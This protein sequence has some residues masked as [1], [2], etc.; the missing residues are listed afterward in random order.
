MQRPCSICTKRALNCAFSSPTSNFIV[1]YQHRLISSALGAY[2]PTSELSYA[3][4]FFDLVG[5]ATSPFIRIFSFEAIG[6]LFRDDEL[7]RRAVPLVGKAYLAQSASSVKSNSRLKHHAWSTLSGLRA[8]VLK[9]LK[10]SL[11][12]QCRTGTLISASLLGLAEIPVEVAGA[13]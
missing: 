5:S 9:S 2:R 6:D 8:K 13:R 7:V 11:E 3:S 1:S 12:R 4:F 10:S